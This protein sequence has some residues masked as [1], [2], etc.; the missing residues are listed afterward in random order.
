M[1]SDELV[2]RLENSIRQNGDRAGSLG[3]LAQLRGAIDQGDFDRAL[4]LLQKIGSSYEN[5]DTQACCCQLQ[6]QIFARKRS[7]AERMNAEVVQ[8]L[9]KAGSACLAARN[10]RDLETVMTELSEQRDALMKIDCS[11]VRESV[12]RSEKAL[13]FVQLWQ[14]YLDFRVRDLVEAKARLIYLANIDISHLMIE[15]SRLVAEIEKIP[16]PEIKPPPPAAPGNV[17]DFKNPDG[18]S[19]ISWTNNDESTD[20]V[21]IQ[22]QK[23][24]GKWFVLEEVPPNVTSLHLPNPD[25]ALSR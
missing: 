13:K 16:D 14:Q 24:D 5:A 22:K 20:C 2:Q 4:S 21:V 6:Q 8:L 19:E 3:A 10:A 23:L 15:R 17:V 1:T 11:I 9:E 18:S 25:V 12:G 7:E